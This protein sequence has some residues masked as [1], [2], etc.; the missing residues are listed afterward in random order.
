M[1]KTEMIQHLRM[2]ACDE[3]VVSGMSNAYD[4]GAEHERDIVCSL[5][6]N[7]IKDDHQLAQNIVDTIRVRE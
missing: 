1:T 6:Y 5:I 3:Q 7:M 4:L 2:A